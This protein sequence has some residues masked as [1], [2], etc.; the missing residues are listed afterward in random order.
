MG[1]ASI[2]EGRLA[3][4]T[5]NPISLGQLGVTLSLL[6]GWGIV[7]REDLS[8]NQALLYF[9]FFWLGVITMSLAGSRGPFACLIAGQLFLGLIALQR[10]GGLRRF[11]SFVIP[12]VLFGIVALVLFGDSIVLLLRLFDILSLDTASSIRVELSQRAWVEFAANPLLGV[13]IE[14]RAFRLYPHNL[15]LE[16]FLATGLFGGLLLVIIMLFSVVHALRLALSGSVASWI[17]VLYIQY[18]VSGMFSGA[19]YGASDFWVLMAAL[20]CSDPSRYSYLTGR[21]HSMSALFRRGSLG[22]VSPT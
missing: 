17:S 6:S 10:T 8:R 14:D 15:V 7:Y 22:S 5:L 11:G 16:A 4:D 19:L 9:M 3:T 21:P 2:L 20:F 1:L 18:F 12:L 13:A